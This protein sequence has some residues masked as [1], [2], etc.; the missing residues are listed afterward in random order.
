MTWGSFIIGVYGA[1]LSTVLAVL[2]WRRDRG[3]F[4]VNPQELRIGIT[5]ET[6][7]WRMVEVVNG[8][9]RPLYLEDF[10]ITLTDEK[11]ISLKDN[12]T[13]FPFKLDE[14]Q[15]HTSFTIDA[16]YLPKQS[17]YPRLHRRGTFY[18]SSL[19]CPVS[20]FACISTY[21][22]IT[23]SKIVGTKIVGENSRDSDR[24]GEN[25]RDSPNTVRH[26]YC[27]ATMN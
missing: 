3:K 2:H 16:K 9:R 26:G 27:Q 1:I 13:E 7:I 21:F 22:L 10:G 24:F 25:S 14:G 6:I 4:V 5:G 15:K 11:S 23:S 18:R 8:G 19:A 17:R 12:H 20:S